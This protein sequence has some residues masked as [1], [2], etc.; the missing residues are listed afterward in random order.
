MNAELK[1]LQKETGVRI[2]NGIAVVS[3]R[4]I[5]KNFGKSHDSV[6]R[7]IRNVLSH[8]DECFFVST[9]VHPINKRVCPEYLIDRSGFALVLNSSYD[10]ET[11]F[12]YLEAF[13]KMEEELGEITP[14]E[15]LVIAREAIKEERRMEAERKEEEKRRK[16][17]TGFFDDLDLS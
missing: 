11:A 3:S 6:M 12:K 17:K 9:F 10:H 1:K 16:G 14:S 7:R 8:G 15:I 5:A 13:R 4:D 2:W